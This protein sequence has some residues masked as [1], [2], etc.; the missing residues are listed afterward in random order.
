M[1]RKQPEPLSR[2][3]AA[4]D[5]VVALQAEIDALCAR[6]TEAI[7][8]FQE[9]FAE[10][11]P[12]EAGR[13]ERRAMNA[14]LACALRIPERT[15]E[16]MMG[17][18]RALVETLPATLGQLA[19]GLFS[20]RHAQVMIDQTAGLSPEDVAA[21]E[22][23]ALGPAKTQT[24]SRFA[25]TVR[26]LRERR[27]PSTMV[28]RSKAAHTERAVSFEPAH[29]GMGYLNVFCDAVDGVAIVDRLSGAA[30]KVHADGDPRTIAQLRVDLLTDKLL[31]RDTT[32]TAFSLSQLEL[33]GDEVTEIVHA[34]ERELGVY[35][36]IVPTVIVTVPFQTLL[37]GDEPATVEGVG[38]IDA[39]TARRLTAQA[40]S[41][42]RLLT[43]PHT[44]AP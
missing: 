27:D 42:Y 32:T 38:P 13:F 41:L 24:V 1:K 12:S 6:R 40:P 22:R 5:Q 7:N 19:D 11:Y 31:D 23:V 43:H 28:E 21:V 39:A 15:A 8:E 34:T 35:D 18:A 10:A 44:G 26:T 25:R 9:T 33:L 2:A 16:R 20:Y 14:E 3:D 17:E 4:L 29:D 37:G 36:G 30:Y